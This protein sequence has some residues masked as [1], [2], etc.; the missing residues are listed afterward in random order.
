MDSYTDGFS[1]AQ[2]YIE[3]NYLKYTGDSLRI[4]PTLMA[5]FYTSEGFL[6]HDN[7]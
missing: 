4:V 5:R 3:I 6:A 1:R 2:F 7:S